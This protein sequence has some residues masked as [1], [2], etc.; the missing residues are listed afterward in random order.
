MLLCLSSGGSRRYR[1]DVL[2]AAGLP[3][4]TVL[5]FRYDQKYLSPGLSQ[6][7]DDT[8]IQG[9][10]ALIAYSDNSSRELQPV[11]IPCRYAKITKARRIGTTVSFDL[12]VAEFALAP[13]LDAFATEIK[14]LS[15][16]QA[17]KRDVDGTLGGLF[18]IALHANPKAITKS[19]KDEFWQSFISQITDRAD[20]RSYDA[21]VLLRGVFDSKGHILPPGDG[22]VYKL[23]GGRQYDLSLYQ[24]HPSR[25]PN[26]DSITA[27]AASDRIQ[28]TSTPTLVLD[29][30]YDHKD[31]H[32]TALPGSE[33]DRSFFQIKIVKKDNPLTAVEF[34][35]NYVMPVPFWRTVGLITGTAAFL[36]IPTVTSAL[37]DSHLHGRKF[38]FL[39]A[40]TLL[41]SLAAAT[42]AA[43]GI[44]RIL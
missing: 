13:D 2:R 16:G 27:S 4:G 10:C 1:D 19:V 17:P 35:L 11:F 33:R 26:G 7:V 22:G 23:Y 3:A 28:F 32:F 29:S 20:F 21:F 36:A 42:I 24:F 6:Q 41:S 37:T 8:S 40:V 34:E 5:R 44:R 18:C 25:T 38:E 31:I 9:R 12:K 15:A 30:R 39:V 14:Q 43:F